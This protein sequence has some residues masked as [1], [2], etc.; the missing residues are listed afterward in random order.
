MRKMLKI[1]GIAV[2]LLSIAFAAPG[3]GQNPE[4][5]YLGYAWETGGFL[6]SEIG[7]ILY[8]TASAG[9]IDPIFGVDLGTEEVTFYMYDLVSQGEIDMG[10]NNV[11]INYIGGTLEIWRD[12]AQNADY[13]VYPPNAT[14]PA[15]FMDGTLMFR[16]NFTY[17]SVYV[18]LVGNGAFE[19]AL[20]GV[21]G[22]IINEVCVDCAYTWGGTIL[23]G[24]GAQ[25]PDGYDLQVDGVFEID[26][27]VANEQ[28]TWGDVKSLFNN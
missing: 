13:G 5:D 14:S 26:G 16:G 27:A 9:L 22:E 10:G 24:T 18:N 7:D 25:I 12:A 8:M 28:S 19:G 21:E 11:L 1:C 3:L 2:L 17:M 23:K 20:N 6:P 15:Y 4:I